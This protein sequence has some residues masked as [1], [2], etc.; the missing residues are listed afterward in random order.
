MNSLQKTQLET[1]A[2]LNL[3]RL[4]ALEE[5]NLILAKDDFFDFFERFSPKPRD[6]KNLILVSD[7]P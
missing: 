6:T 5:E 4:Q 7:S 2:S 1:S 3:N